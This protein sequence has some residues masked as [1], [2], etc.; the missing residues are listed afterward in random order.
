LR[1]F[2]FGEFEVVVCGFEFEIARARETDAEEALSC[3][4]TFT[5]KHKNTPTKATN[6]PPKRKTFITFSFV[7]QNFSDFGRAFLKDFAVPFL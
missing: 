3:A 5:P 1:E 4:R 7:I 2:L 6:S